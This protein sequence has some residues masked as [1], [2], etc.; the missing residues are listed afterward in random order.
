MEWGR[1]F[2][3]RVSFAAHDS[4][5]R[6]ERTS[7]PPDEGVRGMVW[8]AFALYDGEELFMEGGYHKRRMR[9]ST[10]LKERNGA[11]SGMCA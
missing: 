9:V 8:M 10:T 5:L 2:Q 1:P 7:T 3:L 6:N 4:R 11:R